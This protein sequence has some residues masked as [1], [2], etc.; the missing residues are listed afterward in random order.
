MHFG[1]SK[2]GL[3]SVEADFGL[4]GFVGQASGTELSWDITWP[5]VLDDARFAAVSFQSDFAQTQLVRVSESFSTDRSDLS[6]HVGERIRATS[7]L[8][9]PGSIVAFRFAVVVIPNH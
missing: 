7:F 3:M 6:H 1:N 2:G 5:G 4:T 9:P 8:G